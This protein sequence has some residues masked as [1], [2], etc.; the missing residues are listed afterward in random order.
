ME[1]GERSDE[2]LKSFLAKMINDLKKDMLDE[3]AKEI[4]LGPGEESQAHRREDGKNTRGIS[5]MDEKDSKV[6]K[7]FSKEI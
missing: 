2:D 3:C 5:N 7:K 4:S 6:E 1:M